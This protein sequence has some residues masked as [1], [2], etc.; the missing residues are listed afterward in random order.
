MPGRLYAGVAGF[1]YPP[2]RGGF[3]P[4]DARQED[5]L[6][7]YSARLPSVELNTTFYRL[8]SEDALHR[9]AAD[10][11]PD[12]RF[13]AKMNRRIV[14]GDVSYLGTFSERLRA[15]GEK[16]EAVRVQ[17][18]ATR[19][20]DDGFLALL[21]GSLDPEV[22]V[23]F[24]AEHESWAAPEVD[25]ALASAGTVRVNDFEAE[26]PFRYLRLREPPYSDAQLE[27]LAARIAAL[28]AAEI[29]VYCYFKHEDNPRGALYAERLLEAARRR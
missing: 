1:S 23:A 12:F 26:A 29:D 2:W 27:E 25:R 28:L 21:L 22:R 6:R 24:E 14:G 8:P 15:L 16:L 10:T 9:W 11:P 5:F 18:P 19:P 7:L 4:P 3:Y 13:A 17:L 20:R